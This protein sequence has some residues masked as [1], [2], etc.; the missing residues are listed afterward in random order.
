MTC[1][2]VGL[3]LMGFLAVSSE[4][5]ETLYLESVSERYSNYGSGGWIL[6]NDSFIGIRFHTDR[7]VHVS[8][9]FGN[10]YGRNLT[11]FAAIDRLADETAF[12]L[13]VPGFDP[14]SLVAYVER[15]GIDDGTSHDHYFDINRTLSPGSYFLFFGVIGDGTGYMPWGDDARFSNIPLTDYLEWSTFP[16]DP[17]VNGW[18][19]F[20]NSL[21]RAGVVETD[22]PVLVA[23]IG[24]NELWGK[25]NE[26]N[27]GST[28]LISVVVYS[29]HTVDGDISD[30]DATQI[31]PGS[32]SL[33]FGAAQ[34]VAQPLIDQFDARYGDD[35]V[36]GFN[37]QD[38]GISCVDT[39][40]GLT[41]MTY[42]GQE[43][44]GSGEIVIG[45]CDGAGCHP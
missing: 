20:E 31:D 11:L 43:I 42:A 45:D 8:Q 24:I 3:I 7:V 10:I 39:Q 9:V 18:F 14:A 23:D 22:S 33:G 17:N 30:L 25:N 21:I 35:L 28:N 34:N 19:E 26:V 12:P 41:G 2:R 44:I 6:R 38:V 32:L 27:P 5:T 36:V 37:T 4:A 29:T 1:L 15:P 40:L 13:P 16:L